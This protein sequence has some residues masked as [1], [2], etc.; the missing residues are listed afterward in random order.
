VSQEALIT[1]ELKM[2]TGILIVVELRELELDC[3]VVLESEDKLI[4]G[5]L[6]L[7]I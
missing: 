2:H 1:K 3:F 7:T 6:R 5:L 4:K